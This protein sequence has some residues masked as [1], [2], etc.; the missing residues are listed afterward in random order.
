MLEVVGS[1]INFV[2]PLQSPPIALL[3]CGVFLSRVCKKIVS[4][5]SKVSSELWKRLQLSSLI[6]ILLRK[7]PVLANKGSILWP[8]V[9]LSFYLD[10][11]CSPCVCTGSLR[12]TPASSCIPKQGAR[13]EN[14]KL[15]VV[16][17]S[18]THRSFSIAHRRPRG[19]G[20]G[21]G[22]P[23]LTLSVGEQIKENEWMLF[24]CWQQHPCCASFRF[25]SAVTTPNA[26]TKTKHCVSHPVRAV[27]TVTRLTMTFTVLV[28]HLSITS[29]QPF[30][31]DCWSPQV[32]IRCSCYSP[33]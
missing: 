30:S 3:H 15:S 25:L 31:H 18:V 27:Q 17:T 7:D 19:A 6:L 8:E 4:T 2:W 21:S 16:C 12:V 1:Y 24:L 28:V 14:W 11:S 32:L 9:F 23:S 33:T 22:D 20:I 29:A 5:A 10:F 26:P 13:E